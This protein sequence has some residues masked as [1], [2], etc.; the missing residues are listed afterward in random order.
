[1]SDSFWT[2]KTG[3]DFF[4]L[5]GISRATGVPLRCGRCQHEFS[6]EA[7]S[8]EHEC[9]PELL[10]QEEFRLHLPNRSDRPFA[11]VFYDVFAKGLK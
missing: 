8:Y 2:L 11:S 7:A 4:A 10:D 9:A 6:P 1:M 3:L 5:L